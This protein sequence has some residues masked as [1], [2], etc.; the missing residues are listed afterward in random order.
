MTGSA[1]SLNTYRDRLEAA[2]FL[3]S[4]V[5]SRAILKQ[6]PLDLDSGQLEQF[7]QQDKVQ[8]QGLSGQRWSFIS[9]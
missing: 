1:L 2:L 7:L 4:K 9:L 6:S 5:R 8:G 3:S